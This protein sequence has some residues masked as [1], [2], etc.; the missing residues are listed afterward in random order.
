MRHSETGRLSPE[1]GRETPLWVK[2]IYCMNT[3]SVVLEG[4][5]DHRYSVFMSN[6]LRAASR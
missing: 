4:H 6:V 1:A 2:T 3:L 5:Q